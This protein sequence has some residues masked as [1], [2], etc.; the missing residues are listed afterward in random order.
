MNSDLRA[1]LPENDK[2]TM[3]NYI[4]MHANS[5]IPCKNIDDVLRE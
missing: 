4:N 3:E 1:L 2:K 5:N